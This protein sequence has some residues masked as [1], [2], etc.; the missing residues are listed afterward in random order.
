MKI[1]MEPI[2]FVETEAASVPRH[3]SVSDIKG[4][5]IIDKKY[6]GALEDIS[7]GQEIVVIF[8]FHK[9][10]NFQDE[11]LKQN[12]P[13]RKKNIGVFSICSPRRPNPIGMSV[14]KVIKKEENIIYVE[15]IDMFSGT[16]ILDIKPHIKSRHTCPSYKTSYK[17]GYKQ[18][19]AK[20]K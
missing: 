7:A 5:L 2:G 11:L 20:E 13:N 6:L 3:W 1:Q 18:G 15:G 10:P 19:A 8:Y 16:P 4:R 9:S 17:T 12:P 14:L